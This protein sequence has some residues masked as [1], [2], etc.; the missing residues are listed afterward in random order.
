MWEASL[1]AI[2]AEFSKLQS[3]GKWYNTEVFVTLGRKQTPDKSIQMCCIVF[4]L[5]V[6]NQLN[7]LHFKVFKYTDT[8][9]N[10]CLF[11]K[12]LWRMQF[13]DGIS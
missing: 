13:G 8:L 7:E 10:H 6:Q 5:E 9:G 2:A 4:F 1:V 11:Q 3:A 12:Y